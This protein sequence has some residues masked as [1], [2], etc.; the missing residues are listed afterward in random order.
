MREYYTEFFTQYCRFISKDLLSTF[1]NKR[2]RN[3][4]VIYTFYKVF[5]I[6][7]KKSK[8][9]SAKNKAII[10]LKAQIDSYLTDGDLPIYTQMYKTL[11]CS[12]KIFILSISYIE[13]LFPLLNDFNDAVADFNKFH[14]DT[15]F[16]QG[17]I[18]FNNALSHLFRGICN[19][20]TSF[21]Q[22]VSKACTHLHRGSLDYYKT[23]VKDKE[24]LTYE[25]KL[26]LITIRNLEIKSIGLKV[27][28]NDKDE[29]LIKYRTLARSLHDKEK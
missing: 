6:I 15:L 9:S 2:G 26:E 8:N 10:A 22:N 4:K 18:E 16:K 21:E 19:S 20:Q 24:S 3:T 5:F 29:I 14:K 25:Q 28:S 1:D 23:L 13:H 12:N 17:L 7:S 27:S 11:D